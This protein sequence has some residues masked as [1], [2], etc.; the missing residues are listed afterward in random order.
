MQKDNILIPKSKIEEWIRQLRI[1]GKG[2]K[3]KVLEEMKKL[4]GG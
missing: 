1:E 2:T 4:I 3:Q